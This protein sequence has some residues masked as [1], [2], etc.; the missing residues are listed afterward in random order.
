MRCPSL[1]IVHDM[2]LTHGNLR[3]QYRTLDEYTEE[4]NECG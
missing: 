3:S 1:I 2:H 4:M